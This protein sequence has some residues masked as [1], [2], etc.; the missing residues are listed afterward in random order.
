M[1]TECLYGERCIMEKSGE[2]Y[3]LLTVYRA[4]D[5]EPYPTHILALLALYHE[6]QEQTDKVKPCLGSPE[7]LSIEKSLSLC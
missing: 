3:C 4:E 5:G 7:T 1:D 2:L 6:L